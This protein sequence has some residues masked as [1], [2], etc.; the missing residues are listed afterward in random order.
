MG[1][2]DT[3]SCIGPS[4]TVAI[5]LQAD[6][7]L[8]A[9]AQVWRPT[10]GNDETAPIVPSINWSTKGAFTPVNN[11]GQC[12]SCWGFLAYGHC[13]PKWWSHWLQGRRQR[14]HIPQCCDKCWSCLA[15][16]RGSSVFFQH[17]PSG[18]LAG[19]CGTSLVH[20]VLAV[21]FGTSGGTNCWKVKN[22]W[23]PSW[24][25]AGYVFMQRGVDKVQ[26]WTTIRANRVWSPGPVQ[27]R[28]PT[29][30][31]GCCGFGD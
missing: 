16:H 15:C 27:R 8:Q 24:C 19:N 11:Y 26:H 7:W 4:L 2:V 5:I 13:S 22:S 21:S 25:D 12:G 28:D 9:K 23:G 29:R 20:S 31:H 17:Y 18:V 14:E 1:A 6:A 3:L 30:I 10:K